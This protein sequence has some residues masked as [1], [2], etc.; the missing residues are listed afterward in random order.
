MKLATHLAHGRD[1]FLGPLRSPE[2]KVVVCIEHRLFRYD[3]S[4][5][6]HVLS[7][8]VSRADQV[9]MRGLDERSNCERPL[10]LTSVTSDRAAVSVESTGIIIRVGHLAA[11]AR[12]G[13]GQR[14]VPPAAMDIVESALR[15]RISIQVCCDLA[16]RARLL[17]RAEGVA[18][19]FIEVM[20]QASRQTMGVRATEDGA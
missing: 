6:R 5:A 15:R 18:S 4:N 12:L 10:L 13:P 14:P 17:L 7:V 19:S 2:L 3:A 16:V 9:R 11:A 1:A 8:P 20:V